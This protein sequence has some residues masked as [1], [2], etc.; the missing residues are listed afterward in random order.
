M[1]EPDLEPA[2]AAWRRL[3][4][5]CLIQRPDTAPGRMM[6]AEALTHGGKVFAFFTTKGGMVGLG[7]RLGRDFDMEGLGLTDWQHLAPFRT[8]P[9]MKDW[10]VVG[11]ADVARWD[12]MIALAYGQAQHKAKG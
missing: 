8:K 3:S 6:S 11:L 10:I 5:A 9:P 12:E 1:T 7:L 2:R 4:E